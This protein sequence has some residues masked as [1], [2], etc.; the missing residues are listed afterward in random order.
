M[1]TSAPKQSPDGFETVG[2]DDFFEDIFGLSVRGLKSIKCLF[3][4]P[5]AYFTAARHADWQ[6]RFTPSMRL[7][8]GLMTILIGLQ[9][10]WASDA[11]NYMD[12]VTQ[13]PRAFVESQL[14]MDGANIQALQDY[15]MLAAA[16]RINA[17][18]LLI[19]PFIFIACLLLLSAI[20][21]P[22]RN[23]ENFVVSQRYMFGV[24]VPASVVGLVS[25]ILSYLIPASVYT[26]VSN[27]QIA[28]IFVLY[29]ITAYRGPMRDFGKD[30][31]GMSVVMAMVIFAAL[32]TAQIISMVI[33]AMPIIF[34]IG[35]LSN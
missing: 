16:K 8:L 33:A 4:D 31:L 14:T 21:R 18:N 1:K 11:S 19:Y 35:R 26:I 28:I 30:R 2:Y 15:D 27:T 3:V 23:G 9:F 20:F 25:T 29:V 32:F 13:L 24:I 10:I 7:W 17:R 34:E 22:W 5:A 12:S 6:D